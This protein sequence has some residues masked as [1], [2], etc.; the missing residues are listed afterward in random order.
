MKLSGLR[1]PDAGRAWFD[2][3]IGGTGKTGPDVV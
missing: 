2:L 3:V 1:M